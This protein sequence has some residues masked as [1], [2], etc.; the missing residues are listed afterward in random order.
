MNASELDAR[1]WEGLEYL[2]TVSGPG[3]IAE[4]VG[5]FVRDVPGRLIRMKAAIEHRDLQSLGRL[6]HDL[7]SNSATLGALAF[8]ALA[9]R[10]EHAGAEVTEA[11]LVA[12][13]SAVEALL[14]ALLEA[15]AEKVRQYPA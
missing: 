12:M 9:A 6:A 8:A 1:T 5:D 4:M 2:E 14:P 13:V 10:I 3:A 11:E 15:L 7:K